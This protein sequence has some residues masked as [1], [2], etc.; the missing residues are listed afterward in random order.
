MGNLGSQNCRPGHDVVP[1]VLRN[2]QDSCLQSLEA[3]WLM[4]KVVLVVL[5]TSKGVMFLKDSNG[6]I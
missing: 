5:L 2:M 4:E 3:L 6:R 1:L